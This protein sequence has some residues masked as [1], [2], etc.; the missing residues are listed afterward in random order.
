[1]SEQTN[2]DLTVVTRNVRLHEWIGIATG[3]FAEHGLSV[4]MA[5]DSRMSSIPRGATPE[6]AVDDYAPEHIGSASEWGAVKMAQQNGARLISEFYG[7]VPFAIIVPETSSISTFDDVRNRR[8]ASVLNTG[9]YYSLLRDA[10]ARFGGAPFVFVNMPR[11]ERMSAFDKGLVDAAIAFE[12]ELSMALQSGFRC[13]W[14]GEVC[15]LNYVSRRIP[16]ELTDSYV[17]ALKRADAALQAEPEKFLMFWERNMPA[18]AHGRFDYKKF[19]QGERLIFRPYAEDLYDT[20]LSE[21]VEW[22]VLANKQHAAFDQ[23]TL[24]AQ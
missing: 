11:G 16:R 19:S 2:S 8:V 22:D 20:T 15:H 6:V 9:G 21:L 17:A 10:K 4:R 5:A 1:M 14:R 3:L 12:P 18:A 13:V 23:V 7:L 24:T